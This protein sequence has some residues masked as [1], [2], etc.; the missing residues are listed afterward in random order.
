MRLPTQL[1]RRKADTHKGDYGH[2]LVIAGSPRF[3]G[4]SVLTAEAAL[5]SG[6]GLVT[7][8][9]PR[10]IN[11]AIIKIKPK[12][13]MTLPLV[14][15]RQGAIS[16]SA[17]TV[18][19]SFILKVSVVVIGP[20][21][22]SDT[23]TKMLVRLLVASVKKSLVID[24]DGLNALVGNLS[25]IVKGA[26]KRP[27]TVVTPHSGEMAR[28]KWCLV[29]KIQRE[30]K[31]VAKSFANDYNCITV[32]KGHRSIVA[33]PAGQLY[34]NYTGNPGM[35][36]AGSGDVLTGM[37]AA[38]IGQGI[39]GF[40]ATRAAV[41]LHGLAGDIAALN[42]TETCLIASDII[43]SIPQAFKKSLL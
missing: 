12:E 14:Q 16:S 31:E 35:A 4:A 29:D 36:T 18:L 1:L 13:V 20:G 37:I 7:I 32:L 6:A 43:D 11:N 33:S 23:S 30:R 9:L 15:T 25:L 27:V 40:E 8:A 24:A 42:K 2:V 38:F 22:G 28:L 10:G 21:L 19:R 17:F 3:S 41:Y 34:I 26:A 39:P 5:R